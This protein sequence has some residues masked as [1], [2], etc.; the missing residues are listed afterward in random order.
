MKRLN[1][2]C[3]VGLLFVAAAAAA[4][5]ESIVGVRQLGTSA[6]DPSNGVSADGLG[7]V[8]IEGRTEGSLG[9]PNAGGN[10]AFVAKIADP[11]GPEPSTLLLLG[12]GS[13]AV[14]GQGRWI[15]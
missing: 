14:L 5:G 11:A 10:D 4:R 7:N 1:Y 12:L 8:D 13:L 9:G 2:L 15:R 3:L 6:E